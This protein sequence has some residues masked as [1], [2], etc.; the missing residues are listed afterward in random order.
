MNIEQSVLFPTIRF[1]KNV[2]IIHFVV[3]GRVGVT[4]RVGRPPFFIKK[5]CDSQ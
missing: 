4:E 2:R 3:R 5:K 1:L